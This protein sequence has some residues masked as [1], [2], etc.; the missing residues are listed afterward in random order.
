LKGTLHLINAKP[1]EKMHPIASLSVPT[2]LLDVAV[3]NGYAYLACGSAG[4]FIADVRRPD[5]ARLVGKVGLP[6]YILPFAC[7]TTLSVTERQLYVANGRAGIQVYDLSR[8][9]K[10]QTVGSLSTL[11]YAV[12][13]AVSGEHVYV[14]DLRSGLQVVDCRRPN[15]LQILG[16]LGANIKAKGMIVVGDELFVT[17]SMGG[18]LALP[19]PLQASH[20]KRDGPRYL[21]VRFPPLPRAGSYSLSLSDGKKN[22]VLPHA[23]VSP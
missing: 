17:S 7:A 8:G 2:P 20:I 5:K 13:L 16:N 9:D 14:D 1:G 15:S 4:T 23:I 10:P 3:V 21:E 12:S 19:L 11:G 6:D 22:L 18:V